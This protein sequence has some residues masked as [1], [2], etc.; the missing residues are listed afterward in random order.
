MTDDTPRL[1]L[2]L[3]TSG[4]AQKEATHNE[5]LILIDAL[6][7]P[8]VQAVAPGAIPATPVSGQCWIVGNGAGGAWS[9]HD[10]AIAC[11]TDGGWRFVT[12]HD[13]MSAWCIADDKPVRRAASGWIVGE[14]EATII[15]VGGKQVVGS[16]QSAV[17]SAA[18]GAVIDAE[19]RVAI[20]SIL[21][22]MRTHGLI[23]G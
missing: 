19:A 9:G 10:N 16:R 20:N 12:S 6:V 14:I 3:L 15:R 13:G 22:T 4:Q 5:A 8:V 11:W 7:Q 17:A 2:P 21:A 1:G 18:G 23:A